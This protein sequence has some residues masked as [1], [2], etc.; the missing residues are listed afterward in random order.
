MSIRRLRALILPLLPIALAQP[1]CAHSGFVAIAVPVEGIV[2]DGDLSDWP[3]QVTSNSTSPHLDD[4]LSAS[5]R[6]GF[7]AHKERLYV[8]V[9]VTDD[10]RVSSA[11]RGSSWDA[12]DGCQ[13][14]IGSHGGTDTSVIQ[15]AVWGDRREVTGYDG[16]LFS[17][18]KWQGVDVGI[19]VDRG[20]VT[21]EW[22]IP[23]PD[24]SGVAS[25]A[26]LIVDSD[27]D[28]P[29]VVNYWGEGEQ[30]WLPESHGD[31]VLLRPEQSLADLAGRMASASPFGATLINAESASLSVQF[32]ADADGR[33][34]QALPEGGYR[35]WSGENQRKSIHIESPWPTEI[36]V[37]APVDNDRMTLPIGGAVREL[38][39]GLADGSW[40]T[41]GGAQGLPPSPI[42]SIEQDHHG[43]LWLGTG[44]I[45]GSNFPGAGIIRLG[46]GIMTS[47]AKVDGLPTDFVTST[48]RDRNG[49]MW[50]G[51]YGGGVVKVMED[52]LTTYSASDG[53]P[54]NFIVSLAQTPDGYLWFGTEGHGVSRFDGSVFRS[55]TAADEGLGSDSVTQIAVGHEGTLWLGHGLNGGVTR[56]DGDTFE[57]F[58]IGGGLP[59]D[60]IAD[61][62]VTR[63]GRVI[64]ATFDGIAEFNGIEFE[65]VEIDGIPSELVGSLMEDHLGRVWFGTWGKGVFV[66]N[67]SSVEHFTAQD[68]LGSDQ[69]LTMSSDRDGDVWVSTYGGGISRYSGARVR[70]FTA[71]DD[72]PA[73]RVVS[74]FQRANGRILVATEGGIVQFDGESFEPFLDGLLPPGE[75]QALEDAEGGVWVGLGRWGG[76]LVR[77]DDDGV[78]VFGVSDGLTN[79]WVTDIATG[80]DGTLWVGTNGGGIAQFEG[81]RFNWLTTQDGLCGNHITAIHIEDDGRVWVGT[82]DG[83]CFIEEGLPETVTEF[84]NQLVTSVSEDVA[85]RI[86]V[87]L[88]G[89]GIAS[90]T[91]MGWHLLTE[92]DGLPTPFIRA[93]AHTDGDVW[94]ATAGGGAA[95]YD[96]LAFQS[97]QRSDG[98]AHDSVYGFVV[99]DRGTLWIATEGGLTRYRQSPRPPT[100]QLR[101]G[102]Q[103]TE[104]ADLSEIEVSGFSVKVLVEWR[105]LSSRY[106]PDRLSYLVRVN[107]GEWRQISA[108]SSRPD[109]GI[110]HH[111]IEV[112]AVDP[113]MAYSAGATLLVRVTPPYVP[114]GLG[115]GLA[116]S[117][118]ALAVVLISSARR[119]RERDLARAALFQQQQEELRTARR[120]QKALMPSAPP[121][122][123]G[124]EVGGRCHAADDVG[125]DLFQYYDGETRIAALADVTGHGMEAAIPVVMFS[126][127]LDK[128]MEYPGTLEERFSAL[129]RSLCRSLGDR[130]FL[131]LT[132]A[133]IEGRSLRL[134]SCGN[135][136]PLHFHDSEITELRVDG[137]P[138]GI[139]A[140]TQFD[141][142]EAE[143]QV[144]DYLIMYSDGI[145]ETI[146]PSEEMFGYDRTIETVREACIEGISAED[147]VAR[148]MSTAR[149]FAREEPQADD[150]T[151]IV[152]RVE[153]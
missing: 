42:L 153:A 3:D 20:R 15:Y 98:L 100:V 139:R 73:N 59:S 13:V 51:T 63:S 106:T 90:S 64:V 131:C 81:E 127:I 130:K 37:P 18:L 6:L 85:G 8:A 62:L 92:S 71:T 12:Q 10:H 55:F 151:C 145:P 23:L 89:I 24:S 116:M 105:G 9:E 79:E 115:S 124:L 56:S 78:R 134:A 108:R 57:N 87:S 32:L 28:S 126:G 146:N 39:T 114:L 25:L 117:L 19:L 47:Y 80:S 34:S 77:A 102:E 38:G 120:M 65:I 95:R 101:A 45:R 53:L 7:D 137:Y 31:V 43:D 11:P 66:L 141:I 144:G 44:K 16:D 82:K 76:G 91:Q 93:I 142:I 132:M 123:L 99:D 96:G 46:G 68:G 26:M 58:G 40:L 54:S 152:V 27:P 74:L 4:D 138:L 147:L 52:S 143:F 110:G 97:L 2:V 50:F 88:W 111:E 30:H 29:V 149:A 113:D 140:D 84:S 41:Y 119:R 118:L 72:L 36:V 112:V 128:Q 122:M 69:V 136:Y 125:G 75:V 121:E 70:N 21:Y 22:S 49:A 5:F 35:L 67:G 33:F 61:V 1:L 135:P 94:M 14:S 133:E 150:M 60:M 86:W 103:Q 109:L 83:L 129:N 148:L 48:L 107:S 104:F 17:N